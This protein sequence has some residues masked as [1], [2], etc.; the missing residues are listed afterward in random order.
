MIV[1]PDDGVLMT[2]AEA[3]RACGVRPVT[4][5]QWVARGHLVSVGRAPGGGSALYRHVDVAAAEAATRASGKVAYRERGRPVERSVA[6]A[7]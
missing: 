3:A 7:R 4:I 6:P 5:R 2:T 1:A